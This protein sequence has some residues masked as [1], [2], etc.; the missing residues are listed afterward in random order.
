MRS[1][2][3]GT[4]SAAVLLTTAILASSLITHD[5]FAGF[6]HTKSYGQGTSN[7]PSGVTTPNTPTPP[8]DTDGDG[9]PD[10]L[11]SHPNDPNNG[12]DVTAPIFQAC[13]HVWISRHRRQVIFSMSLHWTHQHLPFLI[14]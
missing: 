11:D 6:G 8:L 2:T 13:Q 7:T 5:A 12:R 14:N 4:I 3:Y 9:I 10:A 1:Q